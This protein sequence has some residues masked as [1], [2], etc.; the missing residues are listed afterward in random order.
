MIIKNINW[1]QEDIA[2]AK[3]DGVKLPSEKTYTSE[4]IDIADAESEDEIKDIIADEL[5]CET[6]CRPENFDFEWEDSDSRVYEVT[7]TDTTTYR[8][9]ANSAEEARDQA[10]DWFNER[11][12]EFD[13]KPVAGPADDEL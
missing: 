12:P 6:G 8:I 3:E 13:I 11:E 1:S 9:R 10:W 5:E 4:D 2:E 7:V